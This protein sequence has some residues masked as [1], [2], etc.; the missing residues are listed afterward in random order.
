S[1]TNLVRCPKC[2]ALMAPHR[3]C[4]ACGHYDGRE[5]ISVDD[6]K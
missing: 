6:G 2:H 3:V 5:V 4:K 1:P